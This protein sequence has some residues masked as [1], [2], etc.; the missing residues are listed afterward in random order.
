MLSCG[1]SYTK[2]GQW[3]PGME[4]LERPIDFHPQDWIIIIE[5]LAQWAGPPDYVDGGR[6][7]RTYELIEAI[8]AV[9]G[10]TPG[11]LLLQIDAE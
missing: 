8:A 9:Q 3:R 4:S 5:A 1:S 7:E 10:L 11:E 2:T 6:Q